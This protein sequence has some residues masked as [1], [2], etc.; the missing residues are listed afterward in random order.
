MTARLPSEAVDVSIFHHAAWIE[1]Q[2]DGD[3][4]AAC[5]GGPLVGSALAP[6][7]TESG[8]V[9]PAHPQHT[10]RVPVR[11]DTSRV[12]VTMNASDDDYF[13]E[14]LFVKANGDA[15]VDDYDCASNRRFSVR[16][17]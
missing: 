17:L 16:R 6:V 14:Y 5:G 7:Q 8:S 10:L 2:L 4:T 1:E 9:G 12:L 15:S 13:D 3:S 11:D